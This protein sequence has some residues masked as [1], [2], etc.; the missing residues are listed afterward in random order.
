MDEIKQLLGA[1]KISRSADRM[2]RKMSPTRCGS[3]TAQERPARILHFRRMEKGEATC[4]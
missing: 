4:V 1:E 3:E 2:A